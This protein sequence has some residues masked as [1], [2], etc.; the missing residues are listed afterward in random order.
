MSAHAVRLHPLRLSHRPAL[1]ARPRP[2]AAP[3]SITV[4]GPSAAHARLQPGPESLNAQIQRGIGAARQLDVLRN[5]FLAPGD[6][7]LQPARR[8]DRRP[9]PPTD[10]LTVVL[11]LLDRCEYRSDYL[12]LVS[13]VLQLPRAD[14]A[15]KFD[16]VRLVCN[17]LWYRLRDAPPQ[18]AD[19]KMLLLAHHIRFKLEDAQVMLPWSLVAVGLLCATNCHSVPAMKLYLHAYQNLQQRMPHYL[20][21]RLLDNVANAPSRVVMTNASRRPWSTEHA[22]AA[23]LGFDDAPVDAPYDLS[24]FVPRDNWYCLDRWLKALAQF[25]SYDHLRV[26]WALWL[27]NQ[28]RL[29]PEPCSCPPMAV[30]LNATAKNSDRAPMWR[31]R[32]AGKWDSKYRGDLM[33]IEA[34]RRVGAVEE[35]WMVLKESGI[36]FDVLK[37]RTQAALLAHP[38]YAAPELWTDDMRALMLQTYADELARIETVYGV[39]WVWD[40]QSGTGYHRL[41]DGSVLRSLDDDA[42]S[43]A[44]SE[45]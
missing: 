34:F 30:A 9:A 6:A 18:D 11:R 22:S 24:T 27:E 37:R 32:D 10:R 43:S 5:A 38:E 45:F 8:P 13:S 26:E 23:L 2:P 1:S 39:D 15:F 12:N 20:F 44:D 4:D 21:A 3:R 14:T 36:P 42:G 40:E 28:L 31:L 25:R 16:G 35:A 19:H 7:R 29:A 41:L 17:A 33:F